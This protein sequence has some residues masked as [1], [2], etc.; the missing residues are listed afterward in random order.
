MIS[1]KKIIKQI[2]GANSI[3]FV[4]NFKELLLNYIIDLQLYYKYSNVFKVD[5]FNKKEAKI[6]LYYHS[7]EKGLLYQKIR[8]RF[9][10]ERIKNLH[11]FLNDATVIKK[12]NLSQIRVAYQVMCE[13]YEFHL[14]I[15]V[16]IDDYFSQEQYSSYKKILSDAYDKSFSGAIEYKKDDFYMHNQSNFYDFSSSRKSIRDFTGELIDTELIEKAIS[17][18]LN[19]PSVCNRQSSKVYLLQDKV[20]I[21]KVLSIQNG[22]TGHTENVNQLLIVSSDR[23]YFFSVGERN[24][25]YIDGGIFLMNLLYCLHFYQIANCPA[26]WGKTSKDEAKLSSVI[27]IPASEKIICMIPIGIAKEDFKITLSQRRDLDEIYKYKNI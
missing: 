24:Q 10:Q 6:I 3:S 25:L 1:L 21:D 8:P 18:A 14:K 12:S 16:K 15:D 26:N 7:V 27:N 4:I 20:K 19:A 23:N 5:N 2:F 13:Y 17:L 22:F 9:A 11:I